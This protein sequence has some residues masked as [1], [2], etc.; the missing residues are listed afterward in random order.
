M[1]SF[2][3]RMNFHPMLA[4]SAVRP[5]SQKQRKPVDP[6][7]ISQCRSDKTS[8]CCCL[9]PDDFIFLDKAG[10]IAICFFNRQRA[11]ASYGRTVL[12][13][14]NYKGKLRQWVCDSYSQVMRNRSYNGGEGSA[15]WSSDSFSECCRISGARRAGL[16]LFQ[17]AQASGTSE[18]LISTYRTCGCKWIGPSGLQSCQQLTL[19]ESFIHQ[20][21]FPCEQQL[22]DK[23]REAKEM[24]QNFF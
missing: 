18:G 23:K 2:P 7:I 6:I 14:R 4:K 11:K 19:Y 20:H 1:G 12:H 9:M 21:I 13:I 22:F 3:C 10:D 15:L 8:A 24:Y 17:S 16:W 5:T